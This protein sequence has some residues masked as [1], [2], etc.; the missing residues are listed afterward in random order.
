MKLTIKILSSAL[1]LCSLSLFVVSTATAQRTT[2]KPATTK[3]A[4]NH[5]A[6]SAGTAVG[7]AP[8]PYCDVL[9]G[10]LKTKLGKSANEQC[11]TQHVPCAC[12]DRKSGMTL[13]GSVLVQP[14]DTK[15]HPVKIGTA[16][17]PDGSATAGRNANP[18]G[19]AELHQAAW[20]PEIV[21]SN[22]TLQGTSLEVFIPN[23]DIAGCDREHFAFKWELDGKMISTER[24]VECV[25]GKNVK[26]T[27]TEQSM[28]TTY[29]HF[30][31]LNSCPDTTRN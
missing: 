16:S 18:Q 29:V 25:C 14:T 8:L 21:L 27:I 2:P 30:I 3:T 6:R 17:L 22:C 5:A 10:D 11:S 9:M 24:R 20:V 23:R 31:T 13:Y 1:L 15:C 26:V 28:G 19:S 12:R 4:D 7:T